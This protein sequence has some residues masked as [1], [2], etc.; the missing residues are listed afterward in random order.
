MK[1]VE[2][3]WCFRYCFYIYVI[4]FLTFWTDIALADM[5]YLNPK[6]GRNESNCGRSEDKACASWKYLNQNH[7]PKGGDT[8]CLLNQ[9]GQTALSENMVITSQNAGTSDSPFMI[10]GRCGQQKIRGVIDGSKITDSRV[11]GL[12]ELQGTSYVEIRDLE[13][14]NYPGHDRQGINVTEGSHD[15]RILRPKIHGIGT[16]GAGSIGIAIGAWGEDGGY[17]HRIEGTPPSDRW[18]PDSYDCQL[19][20][21]HWNGLKIENNN[22]KQGSSTFRN[23]AVWDIQGD[24]GNADSIQGSKYARNWTFSDNLI[25][26]GPDGEDAMDLGWGSNSSKCTTQPGSGQYGHVV[27]RNIFTDLKDKNGGAVSRTYLVLNGCTENITIR[28]NIFYGEAPAMQ[29]YAAPKNIKIYNNTIYVQQYAIRF[30]QTIDGF[31]L[32][33]NIIVGCVNRACNNFTRVIHL[34]ANTQAC[35]QLRKHTLWKNNVIVAY[36]DDDRLLRTNIR[37]GTFVPGGCLE[38]DTSTNEVSYT[39]PQK[40]TWENANWFGDRERSKDSSWGKLPAFTNV[41]ARDFNLRPEDDVARDKGRQLSAVKDDLMGR[42]RDNSPDIGALEFQGGPVA[43]PKPQPP[44]HLRIL[45]QD[46]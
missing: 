26:N 6:T 1:T 29:F 46:G 22:I 23:C 25:S 9:D 11:Q 21:I 20:D 35:S 42:L 43:Q 10:D 2:K 24:K 14:R 19:Y 5:F 17:N 7:R 13:I 32:I 38:S 45:K 37:G 27:E 18:D 34:D 39:E 28:N 8:L 4:I 15:I 31:E 33:N 36:G 30:W 16:S 41:N 12:L 44:L 40:E 3:K